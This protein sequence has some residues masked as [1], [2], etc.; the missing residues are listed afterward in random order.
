MPDSRLVALLRNP[1]D[2]AFSK[3]RMLVRMDNEARSFDALV[4]DELQPLALEQARSTTLPLRRSVVVRGEY[5]RLLGT[6]LAHYRRDQLQIHLTDDFER[7]PQAVLDGFLGFLG[8]QPG[9]SPPN[10]GR[11]YFEG[12]DSQ[13]FPVL[14]RMATRNRGGIRGLERRAEGPPPVDALV[15]PLGG[16]HPATAEAG[17]GH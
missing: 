3:Y 7:D 8:M 15:V 16:Q 4:E 2:R 13:R 6:F 14:T 10:L 12:G 11:K 9:W 1:V 17:P 5:G